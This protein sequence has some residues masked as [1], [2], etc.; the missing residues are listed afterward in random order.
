M[1]LEKFYSS[2]FYL[3]STGMFVLS[4]IWW[5][6][7]LLAGLAT[8]ESSGGSSQGDGM[9]VL[10][11]GAV[12]STQILT[13]SALTATACLLWIAGNLEESQAMAKA[14]EKSDG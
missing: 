12:I 10:L 4:A 13:S 14:K 6:I 11:G 5:A 1:S 2:C 9:A 7:V 3:L 8:L